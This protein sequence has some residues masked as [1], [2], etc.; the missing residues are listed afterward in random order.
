MQRKVEEIYLDARALR[1]DGHLNKIR[2]WL[3]PPDPSTNFNEA[4]EQHHQRTGQWFLKSDQYAR[5]KKEHN[6]FL[7][8]NGIPG[9]G[10]TILSSSVVADLKQDIVSKNLVYFYFDFND[11]AKQSLEMAARSL[12][13]QL[14][15]NQKDLRQEVDALYSSCDEGDNQP[16]SESLL[17]LFQRMVQRAGEVW[18]VLDALDECHRRSEGSAGGLLSWIQGLRE[19]G[20]DIHILVTSRPE[21]DIQAAI[22]SWAHIEEI[23]PLQSGHVSDDINA[24]IEARTKTIS[25]WKSRPDIQQKI[26][27]A[28]VN[29]ANGM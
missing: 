28:L 5:W 20:L 7:W 22:K 2:K 3:S 23:F 10:K 26:E 1:A 9:C 16:D 24:Y 18:F 11:V 6:S 12:V 17:Q 15:H 25:R 13:D 21:Q 19:P 29:K 27:C 4:R 8:L 14:Y